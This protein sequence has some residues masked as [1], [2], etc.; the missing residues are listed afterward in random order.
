M[1]M[2]GAYSVYLTTS[3]RP[4]GRGG[5][6]HSEKSLAVHKEGSIRGRVSERVARA[7]IAGSRDHREQRAVASKEQGA[8]CRRRERLW[9]RHVWRP[10]VW[11]PPRGDVWLVC[12][13]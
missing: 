2:T 5:K 13:F 6:L 4:G 8:R 1:R 7:A 12:G 3:S 9:D 11:R 10:L